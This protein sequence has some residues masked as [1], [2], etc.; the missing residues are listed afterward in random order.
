MLKFTS[1]PHFFVDKIRR[2]FFIVSIFKFDKFN[3]FIKSKSSFNITLINQPNF[4]W[5]DSQR[6]N[7]LSLKS[8]FQQLML[9]T[10]E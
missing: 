9:T 10:D 6:L 2:S 4:K 5:L 3:I 7:F 1:Y 8:S